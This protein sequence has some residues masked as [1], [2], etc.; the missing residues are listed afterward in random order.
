M[1]LK[2]LRWLAGPSQVSLDTTVENHVSSLTAVSVHGYEMTIHC[3]AVYF[4]R[5]YQRFFMPTKR[6][7][8]YSIS[9]TVTADAPERLREIAAP[10]TVNWPRECTYYLDE[11]RQK[12]GAVEAYLDLLLA[13]LDRR[14]P[15]RFDW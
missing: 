5:R 11:D 10:F 13:K 7:A 4:K 15:A 12:Q 2:L 8:V 3:K 6:L 1:V 9:N 14:D